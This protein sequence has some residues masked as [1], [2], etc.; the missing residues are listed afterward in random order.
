[1]STVVAQPKQADV[2]PEPGEGQ[3][4]PVLAPFAAFYAAGARHALR[5]LRAMNVRPSELD[6]VAQEV[7]LVVYRQLDHFD[8]Q[9]PAA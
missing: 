3:A 4:A 2:T 6:D 7:F 5:W 9:H 1:M 8:S